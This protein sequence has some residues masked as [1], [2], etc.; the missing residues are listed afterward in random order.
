[1]NTVGENSPSFIMYSGITTFSL[2]EKDTTGIVYHQKVV[3]ENG[4]VTIEAYPELY[5]YGSMY[6]GDRNK[7]NNFIQFAP[8]ANGTFEMLINAKTSFQGGT[9]DLSNALDSLLSGVQES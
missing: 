7:Q 9:S 4:N 6:F 8:N 2:L 3:D 1:M 5:S